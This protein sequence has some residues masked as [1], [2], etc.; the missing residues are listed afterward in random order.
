MSL[1]DPIILICKTF[2]DLAVSLVNKMATWV[3]HPVQT[4]AALGLSKIC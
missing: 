2:P 3:D 1:T 4:V